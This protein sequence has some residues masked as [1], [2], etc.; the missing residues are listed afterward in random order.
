MVPK[1]IDIFN[2]GFDYIRTGFL[3]LAISALASKQTC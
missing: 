1:L 3:K 2:L